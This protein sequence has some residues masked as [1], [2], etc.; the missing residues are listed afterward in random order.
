MYFFIFRYLVKE[1]NVFKRVLMKLPRTNNPL[2]G[3]HNAVNR[4]I[5]KVNP[6]LFRVIKA[7]QDEETNARLKLNHAAR[8][9]KPKQ[10]KV[11]H[12]V[13]E[14]IFHLV[15]NYETEGK[16]DRIQYL[17]MISNTLKK[18]EVIESENVEHEENAK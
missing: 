10:S 17:R 3:L 14:R 12:D 15:S 11:Y 7:F 16:E 2:E 1:W 6:S 4:A 18:V 9:D 13:N 8:G 5:G